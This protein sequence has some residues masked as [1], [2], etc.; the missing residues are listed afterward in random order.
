[1]YRRV[2]QPVLLVLAGVLAGILVVL[3]LAALV[4][5]DETSAKPPIHALEVGFPAVVH[6]T[7]MPECSP[8]PGIVGGQPRL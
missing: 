7:T 8:S 1:M 5:D 6:T 2:V 4:V 3:G